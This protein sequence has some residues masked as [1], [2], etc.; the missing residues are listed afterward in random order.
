MI[1][2][3]KFG[4]LHH[5]PSAL[6]LTFT[7]LLLSIQI[8]KYCQDSSCLFDA[9]VVQYMAYCPFKPIYE[10]TIQHLFTYFLPHIHN[11]TDN[12]VQ[13]KK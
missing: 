8:T 12:A 1:N 7:C 9:L 13:M 11:N 3:K 5:V 2:W 6:P 10:K 4:Q